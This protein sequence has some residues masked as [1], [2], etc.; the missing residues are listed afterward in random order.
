M[1]QGKMKATRATGVYKREIGFAR[2]RFC[3]KVRGGLI[4]LFRNLRF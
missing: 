3:I 1:T 2:L 4:D